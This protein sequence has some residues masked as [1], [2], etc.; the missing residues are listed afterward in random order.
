MMMMNFLH[1]ATT[2]YVYKRIESMYKKRALRFLYA[3][4]YSDDENKYI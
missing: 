3:Y 4:N 2:L 1:N